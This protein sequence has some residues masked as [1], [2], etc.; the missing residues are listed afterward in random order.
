MRRKKKEVK[1]VKMIEVKQEQG[2]M[3]R[4]EEEEV[5]KEGSR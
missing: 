3:A 5:I 1:N 4:E 2:M